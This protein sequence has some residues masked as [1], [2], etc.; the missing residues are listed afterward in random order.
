MA[1]DKMRTDEEI[2]FEMD[3]KHASHLTVVEV[4]LDIRELLQKLIEKK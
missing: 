3:K 2:Q 1:A 4:L